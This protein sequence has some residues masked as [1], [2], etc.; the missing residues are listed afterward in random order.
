[1][2]AFLIDTP[3]KQIVEVE[4]DGD[5]K[6]IYPL[7][8]AEL[9]TAVRINRHGDSIFI[10]DEGLINGNPH[11]WFVHKDYPQPLRGYGLV[12][13]LDLHTG[14]SIEPQVT[15]DELRAA[16]TFPDDSDLKD[17]EEYA[18]I[19]VYGTDDPDEFLRRLMGDQAP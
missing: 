5:Y 2:K 12:L 3:N 19:E 4:W 8:R 10:D 7:I 17:P 11:G 16:T 18:H 6:S 14:D 15:L 9:Y 1:M 13:G